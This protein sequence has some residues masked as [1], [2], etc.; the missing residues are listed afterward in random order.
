M[1]KVILLVGLVVSVI[2]AKA[3][4]VP[5]LSQ[6]YI[7]P[8]LVNPSMA[9]STTEANAFLTYRKQWTGISG[10]PETSAF[11]I[12]SNLK[13]ENMGVGLTFVNDVS[14]IIG[15][16]NLLGSY[17]YKVNLNTE[18]ALTLGTSIGFLQNRV[19]FE[20]IEAENLDDPNLLSDFNN[21]TVLDG[22]IGI[23]YNYGNFIAGFSAAQIFSNSFKYENNS[24]FKEL[25]FGL[26][27]HYTTSL[28]YKMTLSPRWEVQPIVLMR[29]AQGL[30]P[31]F[32]L[33]G[34]ITY[35]NLLWTAVT[36]RAE[37]AT[38]IAFGMNIDQ[39]FVVNYSYEIPNKEVRA[40][41]G[42]SHEFTLGIRLNRIGKKGHSGSGYTPSLDSIYTKTLIDEKFEE[43]DKEIEQ[44]REDIDTYKD[45]LQNLIFEH[46]V[47]MSN[48]SELDTVNNYYMVVGISQSI[49]EAKNLQKN[50]KR[51]AQVETKVIQ[52]EDG[53]WFLLSTGEPGSIREAKSEIKSLKEKQVEEVTEIEPW[54]YK[55]E[56]EKK[57]KYAPVKTTKQ[58]KRK[59]SKHKIYT[60]TKKQKRRKL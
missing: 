40:I 30:D 14:N 23:N 36:Y 7:N 18:Q 45:D 21:K 28:Q 13:N 44:M 32:D 39:R 17:S 9:G 27:R 42:G 19:F 20:R 37:V 4:Q 57:P 11:T 25:G 6:Y 34:V 16:T 56:K 15:R 35:N 24:D 5:L 53:A 43:Q 51:E 26:V 54:V 46:G 52:S 1:K 8:Y 50:L 29:V 3:Q 60:K 22:A 10:S 31:L 12:D 33:S 48:P 47:N 38:S 55:E 58:V 59:D 2:V 49:E 41:A